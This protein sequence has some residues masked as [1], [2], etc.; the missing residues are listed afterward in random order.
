VLHYTLARISQ[1]LAPWAPFYSDYLW[2]ELTAGM[3]VPKSVHLTDWP[4]VN[5]MDQGVLSK[6][7]TA[8]EYIVEGLGQR[9]QAKIKVRQPLQKVKIND[10]T[11]LSPEYIDIIAEELNVKQVEFVN[12]G[13]I[14]V[15]DTTITE[16]LKLEGLMRDIIRQV[17]EAR[18]KAGLEVSDRIHINL[19]SNDE[20][21]KQ[22]IKCHK[23][24]IDVE[25]LAVPG[26]AVG[27]YET[28]VKI[29]GLALG[30]SLSKVEQ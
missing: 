18:K 25:V 19:E 22:A 6:M 20:V 5:K 1:L 11:D 17:Q 12:S 3:D 29:D 27:G 7:A 24:D 15:L 28:S 16:S 23:K 21:L 10:Q 30:I 4:S 8:R 14:V 9:A 26:E 13:E 2:R